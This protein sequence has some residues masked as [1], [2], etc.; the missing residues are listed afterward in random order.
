MMSIADAL[1]RLYRGV[2]FYLCAGAALTLPTAISAQSLADVDSRLLRVERVLDQSLLEQLQRV[3]SLQRELRQL[4]GEIER[5]NND[6]AQLRRRNQS[7]YSDAD[8]RLT[9]LEESAQSGSFFGGDGTG[10]DGLD[11]GVLNEGTLDEGAGG[12]VSGSGSGSGIAG[13]N[14]DTSA[15]S[16]A[17]GDSVGVFV[18]QRSRPSSTPVPIRAN[19]TQA[20]KAAYTRA[21]DLLA[22]G[23]HEQAVD[24][25]DAFLLEYPA[26]PFSF[27]AWYW[28][29][30]AMYAERR[31]DEAIENFRQVTEQF[32]NSTKVPDAQLKI[33]FSLYE[34]GQFATARP[35]LEQVRDQ[36]Q[37]R[38][39]AV[40][41]RKRL[42]KMDREGR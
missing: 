20:E 24:E 22:R 11:E 35:V 32:P 40:L 29:G 4:R 33:G 17:G 37:G 27:N 31:F 26:G 8:A 12:S 13:T 9:D 6:M 19:A 21:Y 1:P 41:A 42:Q 2:G 16:A 30:E 23:Q 14:A 28:K 34:Q 3:D 5:L 15:G 36:F 38:S 25:F 10:F 39:A 7:L 18:S